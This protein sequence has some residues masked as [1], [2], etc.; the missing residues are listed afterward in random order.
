[1]IKTAGVALTNGSQG[2]QVKIKNTKSG[3]VINARVQAVNKV[4]INL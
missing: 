2:E 3:R 4:V 1:M